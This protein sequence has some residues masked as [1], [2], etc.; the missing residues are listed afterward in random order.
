MSAG[1]YSVGSD[2]WPGLAKAM[3][4]C[5]EFVQAAAKIIAMGGAEHSDGSNG[6]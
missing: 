2:N 1:P 4:E 5:G 6:H 3:E